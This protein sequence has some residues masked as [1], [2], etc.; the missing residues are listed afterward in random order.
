[1]SIAGD[2]PFGESG[3]LA[4]QS[5]RYPRLDAVD[6]HTA[7][8]LNRVFERSDGFTRGS[9]RL[10]DLS[11]VQSASSG[12]PLAA[13]DCLATL[14]G[15]LVGN[16]IVS[17]FQGDGLDLLTVC[18]S[19]LVVLPVAQLAGLYPGIGRNPIVEFRQIARSMVICSIVFAAV[20]C[21][22]KPE[23]WATFALAGCCVFTISLPVTVVARDVARQ[24]LSRFKAWGVRTLVVAEPDTA[25]QIFRRLVRDGKEGFQPIAVLLDSEIYGDRRSDFYQGGIP[26]FDLSQA[27]SVANRL[28]VTHVIVSSDAGSSLLQRWQAK[29][30]A[31]PNR[32]FISP[33]QFNVGIWDHVYSV[34]S[35]NGLRLSGVHPNSVKLVM[36]RCG[37]VVLSSIA[38]V[39][40][41]PFLLTC[42]LL[43]KVTSKGPVFYGQKRLGKGGREFTAWKFRTMVEDADGVLEEYLAANPEAAEEWERTHKLSKDPRITWIGRFLRKSSL[44]EIPQL[45][46]VIVGEMSLVGPRPIVDSPQYD[47]IYVSQYPAEFEAYKSVRPGLTGMWQ[48]RCRNREV[49]DMR[50]FYDMYYIRN[51]CIWLDLYLIMRTIKTVLGGEGS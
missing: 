34:G 46:N 4:E 1:M 25:K 42:S 17:L 32:I 3:E 45:W 9:T 14:L 15:M 20:G 16:V 37:D 12:I 40:G 7:E 30:R 29:L 21:V 18:V 27:A 5:S 28:G 10:A 41:A 26:V 24:L 23:F 19:S 50:I 48:V 33:E 35:S 8:T 51:W 2:F 36:K 43:I 39:L 47:G 38:L 31:V 22:A 49:Y 11:I 44:D 13:C 6:R